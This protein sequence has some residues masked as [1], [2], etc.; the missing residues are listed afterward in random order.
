MISP[1]R[2]SDG[3]PIQRMLLLCAVIEKRLKLSLWSRDVYLNVVGGLR[4][5]E[6]AA[7]LAVVVAV[8]SSLTGLRVQPGMA[9]VGE[10][11]CEGGCGLA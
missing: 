9:F 7:D 6:P 11:G 10:W 2:A 4:I 3:F 5:S 1:R 8:V